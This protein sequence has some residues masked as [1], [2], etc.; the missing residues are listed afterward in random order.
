[1][2]DSKLKDALKKVML[3]GVVATTL[4]AI[5]VTPSSWD[6]QADHHQ[7]SKSKH[8]CGEGSCGEKKG[9]EGS[10]GEKKGSH[11]GCGENGCGN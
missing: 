11:K 8:G 3:G 5:D 10:C 4:T 6:A 7:E 9:S 2:T 1:M